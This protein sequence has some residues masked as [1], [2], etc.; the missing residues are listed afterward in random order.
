[1]RHAPAPNDWRKASHGSPRG[2]S[3]APGAGTENPATAG[4]IQ[5]VTAR[6]LNSDGRKFPANPDNLK[7]TKTMKTIQIYSAMTRNARAAALKSEVGGFGKG[8]KTIAKILH[9]AEHAGDFDGGESLNAFA[10]RV[11]GAELRRECQG[12]YEACRVLNA[13]RDKSVCMTEEQFDGVRGF[14][15]VSISGLLGKNGDP[16]KL[17]RAVEIALSGAK[18]ICAKLKELTKK[19]KKT[20]GVQDPEKTPPLENNEVFPD[21]SDL[22]VTTYQVPD[23]I[24]ILNHPEILARLVAEAQGAETAEDCDMI[25]TILDKIAEMAEARKQALGIAKGDAAKPAKR[26]SSKATPAAQL[27]L[28]A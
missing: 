6:L 25:V 28:V 11:T 9:A 3:L 22:N 26:K 15:L 4:K 18:D 7:P 1:M 5:C 24:V 13:M 19:T 14:A 8:Q 27:E 2:L 23:S 10:Q 12:V 20:P 21:I 16:E 17:A